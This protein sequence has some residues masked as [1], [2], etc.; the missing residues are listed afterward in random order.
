MGNASGGQCY[1]TDILINMYIRFLM[2][3]DT[4]YVTIIKNI[5]GANMIAGRKIVYKDCVYESESSSSDS[6]SS[7]EYVDDK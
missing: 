4:S 1:K 5:S 7:S 6:D 2:S 3:K